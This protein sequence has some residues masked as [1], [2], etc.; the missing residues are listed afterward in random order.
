VTHRLP[1][2]AKAAVALAVAAVA[3][4]ATTAAVATYWLLRTLGRHLDT[5]R[6]SHQETTR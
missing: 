3:G 1:V 6:P 5:S 2:T 4:D